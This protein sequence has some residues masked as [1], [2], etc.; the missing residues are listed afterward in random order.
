M[1]PEGRRSACATFLLCFWNTLE[2]KEIPFITG[3]DIHLSDRI[4]VEHLPGENAAE[5]ECIGCW[6]SGS[7]IDKKKKAKKLESPRGS[8]GN[9][10]LLQGITASQLNDRMVWVGRCLQGRKHGC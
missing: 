2:P 5:F 9:F 1:V 10:P 6:S 8:C 7:S 3:H 4:P